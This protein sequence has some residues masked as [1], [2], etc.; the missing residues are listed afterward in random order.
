M[1]ARRLFLGALVGDWVFGW[2]AYVNEQAA[3]KQLVVASEF[4]SHV[5]ITALGI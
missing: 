2:F 5:V 3:H 4:V 1:G